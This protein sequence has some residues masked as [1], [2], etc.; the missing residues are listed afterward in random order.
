MQG[1]PPREPNG[2]SRDTPET[3]RGS[4]G[5]IYEHTNTE[6]KA[7]G[8]SLEGPAEPWRA[9]PRRENVRGAGLQG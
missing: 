1:L 5:L 6:E 4:H 9:A 2:P 3:G 8:R 7:W